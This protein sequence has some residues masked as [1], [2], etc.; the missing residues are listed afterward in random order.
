[1]YVVIQTELF[2]TDIPDDQIGSWFLGADCAGW[3]Y[4]RLLPISGIKGSLSPVMED[5]GW[6]MELEVNG[7]IV[8][9]CVWQYIDQEKLW[10]LGVAAKK[11]IL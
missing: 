10:V 8:Q 2:F 3:F 7:V 9:I 1:M 6:I 11:E 5:R 4:A